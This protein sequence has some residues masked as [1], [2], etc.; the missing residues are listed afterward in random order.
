M[1]SRTLFS[2]KPTETSHALR[3]GFGPFMYK[4][5]SNSFTQQLRYEVQK[6]SF[7]KIL[8]PFL[9]KLPLFSKMKNWKNKVTECHLIGISMMSGPNFWKKVSF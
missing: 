9:E 6:I 7:S 1:P 2:L 8:L 5:S 3:K 4:I